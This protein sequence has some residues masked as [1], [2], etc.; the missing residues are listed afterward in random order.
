MAKGEDLSGKIFGRLIVTAFS[1]KC[2]SRHNHW[3]CLCECGNVVTKRGGDLKGGVKSCG[4]LVGDVNR[5]RLLKH[6]M[7][8]TPPYKAW[9]HARARTTDPLNK[10]WADYGGRGIKFCKE[11]DDSFETF[12]EDMCST[13]APGL[14]LDRIDVDGHYCKENCRWTTFSVQDHNK[15]KRSGCSSKFLGVALHKATGKWQAVITASGKSEYFGVFTSEQDAA[16]AYDNRSEE[17]YGD[18]PNKTTKGET[19]AS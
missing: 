16:L 1:H 10:A 2:A 4:C 17:L 11:W 15:R 19:N 18:R 5:E 7:G 6:G 8:N 9:G 13:W 14:T 12:W 3:I